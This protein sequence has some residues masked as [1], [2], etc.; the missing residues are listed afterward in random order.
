MLFLYRAVEKS[1]FRDD[2][3]WEMADAG[4]F[5]GSLVKKMQMI[6][7]IKAYLRPK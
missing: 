7:F 1:V 3:L 2:F 6:V 5:G 4:D